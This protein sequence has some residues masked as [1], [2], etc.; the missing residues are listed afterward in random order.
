ME[1]FAKIGQTGEFREGRPKNISVEGRDV[2][3]VRV[4]GTVHAFENNCP[5]QHSS[6]LHQ[7]LVEE[8]SI[9][10]PMHGWTF[11][12]GSGRSTSG[13]GSLKKRAVSVVDDWVWVQS[14]E[15]SQ[16]FPLFDGK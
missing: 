1:G 13:S 9:T 12:I 4:A 3:V 15:V 2:V 8:C 5:H 7:G 10:C 11:D 16:D 14:K 6:L